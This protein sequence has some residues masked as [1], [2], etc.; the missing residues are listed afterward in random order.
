MKRT[1]ELTNAEEEIMEFF[2]HE[3]RKISFKEALE[4]CNNT[5]NKEWKKQTLSTYLKKLQLD[6]LIGVDSTHKNYMYYPVCS[7]EKY[8]QAWTKKIVGDFFDNSISKL[9]AAFV[10]NEKLSDEEA[11]NLRKLI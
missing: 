5:L 1:Y 7:K 4:Y 10:E 11:E 6:G 9:V 2:W 8:A 3:N